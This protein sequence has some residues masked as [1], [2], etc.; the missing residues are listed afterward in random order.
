MIDGRGCAA[1][2]GGPLIEGVGGLHTNVTRCVMGSGVGAVNYVVGKPAEG[3]EGHDALAL[4]AWEEGGTEI[5]A[6]GVLADNLHT[7]AVSP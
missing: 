1:V 2:G 4:A 6:F 3:V 5:E 7:V